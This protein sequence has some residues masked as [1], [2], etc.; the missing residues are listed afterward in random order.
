MHVYR[1]T[2]KGL[3]TVGYYTISGGFQDWHPLKDFSKEYNAAAFVHFLNG[4]T[5][6]PIDAARFTETEG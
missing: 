5:G 4:G 6:S 3:Y 2:E 1:K